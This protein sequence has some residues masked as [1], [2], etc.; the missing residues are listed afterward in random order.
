MDLFITTK[1]V[2]SY[3]KYNLA[4]QALKVNNSNVKDTELYWERSGS[5]VEPLTQDGRALGLSL[6]RISV[7]CF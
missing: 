7:L 5:V 3:A 4:A 6:T 2:W 1:L